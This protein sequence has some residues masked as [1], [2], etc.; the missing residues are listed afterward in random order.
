MSN[1]TGLKLSLIVAACLVLIAGCTIASRPKGDIE[2]VR[3]CSVDGPEQIRSRSGQARSLDDL[4]AMA[5]T[6]QYVLMGEVH[7]N[8]IHHANQTAVLER[9]SRHGTHE[10]LFFEMLDPGHNAI[11]AGYREEG[12]TSEALQ[13]ALRWSAR[14]WPVWESY[15]PLLETAR[16]G[17][18]KMRGANIPDD[19]LPYV[20]LYG[21]LA[22]PRR[23]RNEIGLG[24]DDPFLGNRGIME[25]LIRRFHDVEEAFVPALVVAQYAKDAHMAHEMM[26]ARSSAIL[27]AGNYHVQNNIGVPVHLARHDA[28]ASVL[29]V[30]MVE[31]TD[32]A[33]TPESYFVATPPELRDYDLLWF[34][35]TRCPP[36]GPDSR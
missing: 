17:R 16:A 22:F 13:G 21:G 6:S 7:A 31:L 26:G 20:T 25:T 33:P 1:P 3:S 29:T 8:P 23:K 19:L 28:D 10:Y 2:P 36:S 14:G 34:T 11:L 35:D 5:R 9:L 15:F 30:A 18:M 27:V 32:A 12:A 24:E 4:V